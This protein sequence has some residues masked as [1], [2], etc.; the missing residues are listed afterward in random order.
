MLSD[1][2]LQQQ[3]KGECR[4]MADRII[5]MRTALKK[6][7]IEAGTCRDWSHITKQIGMFCYSGLTPE[8]VDRMKV[9]H[10][11]YITRDGRISMAGLTSSN[12]R[13]VANAIHSVTKE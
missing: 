3:W 13:Y 8:Q 5:T 1:P 11:I 7:L 12:V 4:Q 9:E 10:H 2:E 6:A